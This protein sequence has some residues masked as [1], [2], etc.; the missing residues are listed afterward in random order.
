MLVDL[1]HSNII[2]MLYCVSSQETKLLVYEHMENRSLDQWLHR[3]K[4]AGKSTPLDWLIRL[5]I[6]IDVAR[7]LSYMHEDFV[8]P[9]IHRNVMCTNIHLD[10]GFKAKIAD[11]RLA[12]ILALLENRFLQTGKIDFSRQLKIIFAGG[13]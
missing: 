11:F 7:G 5:A 6:A 1:Q 12:W 13:L 3:H 9:V 2:D 4:R 8:Q 10:R